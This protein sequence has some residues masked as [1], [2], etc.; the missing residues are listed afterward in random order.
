MTS[1]TERRPARLDYR[2]DLDGVRAIAVL[3]VLGFHVNFGQPGMQA[4]FGGGFLGV[5]VFFVLS[6][7]LITELLLSEW[8]HR[9]AVSFRAF[10]ERRS[11]RLLPG[12][13]VLLVVFGA[14]S[15]LLHH[16]GTALAKG[17][18]TQLVY[19]NAAHQVAPSALSVSHIWTLVVEWEFYLV[20]PA[21]MIWMLRHRSP[22]ALL[23]LTASLVVA[24][25]AFRAGVY[26]WHH[27]YI[28][29]YHVAWLRVDE[30]LVG[31]LVAQ[32]G[33]RLRV[34]GWARTVGL[35]VILVCI[36]RGVVT[37][38]WLYLGG[39]TGIAVATAAVVAPY[40]GGKSWWGRTVLSTWPLPWIGRISYSLYLWSVPVA[41]EM[42]R[43]TGS[44]PKPLRIIVATVAS[45]VL[46]SLSYYL[47]E[48]TFRRNSRRAL[49]PPADP[50][51]STSQ[52]IGVRR[53]KR[54]EPA[55]VQQ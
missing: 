9:G 23:Q 13:A 52:V 1:T 20:W 39:M 29:T 24:D 48:R 34:P 8:A 18:L 21:V 36:S 10:Y 47:V 43:D 51:P 22:R 15:T 11:R 25:A 4:I 53:R 7:L 31:S 37:Q 5:D 38:S 41:A 35:A 44:W 3:A 19:E 33:S 42:L 17:L 12:L 54:A 14:A 26:A 30:L 46:A 45:F 50:P 28:L 2:P 27:N 49:T 40:D 6:G 16:D 32:L 55:V